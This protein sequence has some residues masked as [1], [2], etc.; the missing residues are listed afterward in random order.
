VLSR[1]N[2][3][4]TANARI[5]GREELIEKLKSKLTLKQSPSDA[6]LILYAYDAWAEDCVKHLI[7]DFAFAIW[8]GRLQRLFAARDHFGV[9]P[10]FFA[11]LPN[12]FIFSS[13]LNDLRHDPRVSDTLN[14]AAIGDYLLF[15]LNQDLSTTIF[16]DIQ[17]LPPAHCLTVANGAIKIR[18]YWTPEVSA[19]VRFRDPQS[20]VERFSELL[21]RAIADRLRTDCLAISMSG[22][23][24]STSLAA[25]ARKQLK[26][27]A[28]LHAFTIVYD[29]L[30]PDQERHYSRLAAEHLGIAITHI[31]ADRYSLFDE[32]VPGDMDQPE[33]FLLSPLT[34]QFNDLLRLCARHG[35]IAF[36]GYDG[37]AFMSEPRNSRF[38][39]RSKLRRMIR[40]R[41]AEPLLPEWFDESFASRT[42]L[43]DRWKESLTSPVDPIQTR[44][45]AIRALNSKV[46][47]ALFEGYDPGA[48]KLPLEVRHPYIDLRLVEYLLAIPAVPWCVNKH[49]LR[50]AMKDILPAAVLNRQKTPLAGDPA[51]QLVRRASVRW[52]DRF[53]VNP[54]LPNFV[55]LNR[56]RSVADEETSDAVWAS[57]RV[58]A[59]NYWLTN[60]KPVDR[61]NIANTGK[62]YRHV[63]DL[64]SP[65][66]LKTETTHGT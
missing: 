45:S 60:S 22:G 17:R 21:S 31:N 58:F 47:T 19:G 50:I 53:E 59:L 13:T 56:R 5:D 36:T 43:Y 52:L 16:K 18:R 39:I 41:P 7:G 30:I 44:P 33:P 12:D 24:D 28:A 29:T 57:L 9:K 20:Y 40:R 51:L 66:R 25:I 62:Q 37:D 35:S 42:N 6:E 63:H 64:I 10:F 48:T 27:N 8:D 55:N 23:L 32:Q 65:D 15:G 26:D 38:K 14:E 34:G 1:E 11:H 61:R 46:W 54:Q 4:L 2:L 49:I 3:W